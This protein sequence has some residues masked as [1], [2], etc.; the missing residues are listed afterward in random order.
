MVGVG[1]RRG[2]A[3]I[4]S[5]VLTLAALVQPGL[6]WA[7]AQLWRSWRGGLSLL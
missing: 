7:Q 1:F 3:H 4:L 2:S 5:R 6:S